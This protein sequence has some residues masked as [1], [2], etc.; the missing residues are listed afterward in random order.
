M[1]IGF[2]Q[3]YKI[4]I[5]KFIASEKN[6]KMFLQTHLQITKAIRFFHALFAHVS[7]LNWVLFRC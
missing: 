3:Q 4:K 6:M 1:G 7:T 2:G 5:K